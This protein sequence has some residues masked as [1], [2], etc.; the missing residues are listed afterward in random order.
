MRVNLFL[1]AL[2]LLSLLLLYSC[3]SGSYDNDAAI[4]P[5][6]TKAETKPEIRQEISKPKTEI[7]TET[8][9]DSR[10]STGRYSVQIGAFV[11]EANAQGFAQKAE[12]LFDI[13]V[14]CS[15]IDGFYK[16][17]LGSCSTRAD[18]IALLGRVK[19]VGYADSF[20]TETNK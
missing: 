9:K 5:Q 1:A 16:V 18:A 7:K 12:E 17:R 3:N 19:S 4:E 2:F 14:K 11:S 6:M 13:D 15:L 10:P 20:V 8:I